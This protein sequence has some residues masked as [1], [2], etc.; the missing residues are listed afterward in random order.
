[1]K[2][3]VLVIIK[4]DAFNK[5]IVGNIFLKFAQTDLKIV[6]MRVVKPTPEF[7]EEHYQNIKN[8]PFFEEATSYLLGKYH[9]QK[10]IIVIIYHGAN[11]IQECRRIAGATNPEDAEPSSI[12][13]AY[14]RITT[15]G[16][17]ENVV[18]VSSDPKE[19]EREIK[20]WFD[21]EDIITNL[22]PSKIE[23]KISYK[24]RIWK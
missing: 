5:R 23:T 10:K 2:E 19:A 20:L 11:A 1:M 17:Y 14:G 12:R 3:A 9:Q 21:P 18:H 13:G 8:Q 7:I 6:A 15:K 24:K 22:Y 16:I 4:P